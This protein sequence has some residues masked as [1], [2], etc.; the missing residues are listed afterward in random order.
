M[1]D[2]DIDSRQSFAKRGGNLRLQTTIKTNIFTIKNKELSQILKKTNKRYNNKGEQA[3]LNI[4]KSF[5]YLDNKFSNANIELYLNNAKTIFKHFDNMN[6]MTLASSYL[7][8]HNLQLRMID[9]LNY[10]DFDTYAN[11]YANLIVQKGKNSNYNDN[12]IKH[13]MDIMRYLHH[14][15]LINSKEKII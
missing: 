5:E 7:I 12:I 15:L 3:E 11:D 8:Y 2:R 10:N 14:I 9:D 4:K 13:K 6:M 1:D